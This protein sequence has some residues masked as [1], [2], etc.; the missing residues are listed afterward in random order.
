M[1]V[2]C[3]FTYKIHSERRKMVRLR[4]FHSKKNQ[5]H[6]INNRRKKNRNTYDNLLIT[7]K[8]I[9][10]MFNVN[11]CKVYSETEKDSFLMCHK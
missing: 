3:I 9:T 1:Y 8:A 4:A 6:I 2:V 5:N 11:V 10:K 7:L